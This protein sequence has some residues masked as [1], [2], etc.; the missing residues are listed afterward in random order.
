MSR[1]S[2]RPKW[3]IDG[4]K[5]ETNIITDQV[6]EVRG[7][8]SRFAVVGPFELFCGMSLGGDVN[9]RLPPNSSGQTRP[10]DWPAGLF[11]GYKGEGEAGGG[12]VNDITRGNVNLGQ[13]RITFP[14]TFDGRTPSSICHPAAERNGK[15]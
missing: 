7:E 5:R 12:G 13:H 1:V 3:V 11:L 4:E 6:G 15:I 10:S 8:K 14:R 9:R 2:R